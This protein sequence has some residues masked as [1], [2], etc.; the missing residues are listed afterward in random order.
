[1]KYTIITVTY[2]AQADIEKTMESVL[3]QD[4]RD[5]EYLIIDG[6]SKDRTLEIVENMKQKY[7]AD[8]KVYSEMD[9]GVYNAMNKGIERAKGDYIIFV[10]AGDFLYE[11]GTLSSLAEQI[12]RGGEAIY[13]GNTCMMQDGKPLGVYDFKKNNHTVLRGLLHYKMPCH[14]SVVAPARLLK[15]YCFDEKYKMRAD[16]DWIVKCYRK[17]TKF[18]LIDDIVAGYDM[19]GETSRIDNQLF[20]KSESEMIVRKYYPIYYILSQAFNL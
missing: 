6:K 8:I 17:G 15:K 3:L 18:C 5:Y 19:G 9:T 16:Y 4:Y 1:M 12:E 7:D 20:M 14:Q 13:C 11:K 2:N 10:N